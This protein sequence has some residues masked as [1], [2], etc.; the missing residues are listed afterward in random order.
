MVRMWYEC[1]KCGCDGSV[2]RTN[3]VGDRLYVCDKCAALWWVRRDAAPPDHVAD[4]H[5]MMTDADTVA[6]M[7]NVA[8]IASAHCNGKADHMAIRM[9]LAALQGHKSSLTAALDGMHGASPTQQTDTDTSIGAWR[10]AVDAATERLDVL[11]K[12]QQGV[13]VTD[14]DTVAKLWRVANATRE[15]MTVC[16]AHQ[17]DDLLD[18]LHGAPQP[19]QA[20]DEP[21]TVVCDRN[22]ARFMFE[23]DARLIALGHAVEA[24]P[25]G[26]A[27][28]HDIVPEDQ[29][30]CYSYQTYQGVRIVRGAT[31]AKALGLG[32]EKGEA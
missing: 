24:I 8:Y 31:L 10:D 3:R 26:S 27:I 15:L 18:D 16:N 13:V 20:Q 22:G 4:P 9:A 7:Q 23:D 25:K 28:Y 1:F 32:A 29:P 5:A 12:Q 21:D 11:L 2:M 19:P 6:K 14:A 30:W 17:I